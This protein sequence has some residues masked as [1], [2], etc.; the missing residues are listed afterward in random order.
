MVVT[1]YAS[2]LLVCALACAPELAQASFSDQT[3]SAGLTHTTALPF[4]MMQRQMYCGASVGDFNADG[5]PDLFMLG[6]GDAGTADALYLNNGDG[7]FTD[8]AAAWGVQKVHRGR[9]TT[10]GDFNNDGWDDIFVTSGGDMT[11]GDRVGQ[12]MLYRN[13]GNGTFT[14]IAVSAG[15]NQS[16]F[17]LLTA[18]GAAFGDYDLDGDLD[19]YVCNW[20]GTDGNDLYLNNGDETFTDATGAAGLGHHHYGFSPRFVDM[21]G[22]RYPELIIA[23]DYGTSKYYVNDGDGTF[24]R[25]TTT[26]TGVEDN[27]MGSV[28]GDFNRDGLPDWYVTS[29]YNPATVQDGNFMYI[30]QGNDTYTVVP[31]AD[32]ARDGG[33]GW[34]AEAI[35]IDHD[36]WT[37][38]VETNGWMPTEWLTENSY[39]WRNNG[40]LTFTEVQGAGTGFQHVSQGRGLLLIDYDRDADMDIVMTGWDEPVTLFRN[41]ISGPNTN[42][43]EILLDTDAS[44]TLAPDGYG[45]KVTITAGGVTQHAW[46]NGGSTY[47][48]R[49]QMATHF[50]IGAATT[51]DIT[52]EWSDGS[53]TTANAVA[54]NQIVTLAP[55]SGGGPSPGESSDGSGGPGELMSAAYNRGTGMIDVA[56]APACDASDHTIYY[57]DLANVS[58]YT[59]TG[60]ACWRGNTGVSSFDPAG[61]SSAFFMIVGNNGVVEGSYG[62][63][64][65]GSE[66]PQDTT[67]GCQLPQDLSGV[68]GLP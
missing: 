59:Y 30:N 49:S 34:G 2:V 37:D 36:G 16:S 47:L 54:A 41:D 53:T 10:V 61:L 15:V 31:E 66:R 40:D 22:D 62:R 12:H 7:T 65:F 46:P 33:W 64:R 58:T 28:I 50:G 24:T 3:A 4:D 18:T 26:G 39:M 56:F 38:I 45:S 21:N 5:W 17:A 32:G 6:G 48:G 44:A 51:V 11:G 57:G 68:C 29:I 52:V 23:S 35:D 8:H 42:S 27:G 20:E 67:A 14:D 43:I 1:R 25:N 19:L 60:A 13:N 55:S 63:D 9:G